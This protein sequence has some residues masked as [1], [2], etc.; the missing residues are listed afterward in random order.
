MRTQ[1]KMVVGVQVMEGFQRSARS[2][3]LISLGIRVP[4]NALEDMRKWV[5]VAV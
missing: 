5:L 2:L 1:F 4:R 3:E